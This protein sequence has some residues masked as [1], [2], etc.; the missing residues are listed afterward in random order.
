VAIS[1]W[2][3]VGPSVRG[4]NFTFAARN[5]FYFLGKVICGTEN[6]YSFYIY[7]KGFEESALV[8]GRGN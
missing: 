5:H 4:F 6:A 3:H 2:V 8:A 7:G 1:S